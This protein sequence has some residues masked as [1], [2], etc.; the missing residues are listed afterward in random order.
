M[1]NSAMDIACELCRPGIARRLYLSA[2]RGAWIIPNY[3]LGRP[4]DRLGVGGAWVPW[5]VQSLL[6]ELLIR[7]TVGAPWRYGLPR[8]DHPP[9]AAHP[10]VSQDLPVRLGRGDIVPKPA[11]AAL[12][13]EK[14]HFVD[15]STVEADAIIYCTGYRLSFPFFAPEF[16]SAPGNHLPLWQRLVRPSE[17]DLFFV[18][19]V[20]P[21]GAAMPIA[22]AQAKLIAAL[23]AGEY[24]LPSA[25]EMTAQMAREDRAL[26][27]RY[28]ASERRTMQVDFER[29]L[30][31]LARE[32]RAGARRAALR[33]R[34]RVRAGGAPS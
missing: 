10:T 3:V 6:A 29:Y 4:M 18:G 24:A 20:Q 25:A 34:G 13:G 28:V 23:L 32:R 7:L 27:R 30:A 14:V 33:R 21:L 1:G 2:R 31:E 22:E 9:L 16:L 19:L 5:R 26:R 11:I 17:A 12:E 8:P 15:G